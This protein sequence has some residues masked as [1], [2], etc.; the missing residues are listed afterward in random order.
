[1]TYRDCFAY[2]G[3]KCVALKV[4][5]CKEEP[6]AFMKS[7]QQNDKETKKCLERIKTL[8]ENQKRK[9]IQKYYNGKKYLIDDREVLP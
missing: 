1:M 8:G 7:T 6:C 4:E 3:G 2:H 5:K 9:I